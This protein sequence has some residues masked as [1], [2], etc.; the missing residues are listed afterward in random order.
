MTGPI[1]RAARFDELTV[2]QLHDLLRLRV[3]VF[4]VEQDCPY[5][6]IDGR[7][8]DPATEHLWVEVDGEVA[9]CLRILDDG[10]T[11]RIGRV[12]TAQEQR[13]QGYAA[14][15][16]RMALGRIGDRPTVLE[17]QAYLEEWYGQFGFVR[18]GEDYL[19]D[20]ILH[21]PMVRA[22]PSGP[23]S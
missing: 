14:Q 10:V 2:R 19:E 12:A 11:A 21:V 5:P 22:V 7:D 6:E 8:T 4:V 15:L 9:A 16:M 23:D 13:G 17:A 3:D 1:A 20:G 18:T